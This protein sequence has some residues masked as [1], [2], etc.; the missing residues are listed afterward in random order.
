MKNN[1][2]FK[3]SFLVSFFFFLLFPGSAG[4]A[5]AADIST[6]SFNS[7]LNCYGAY[8]LPDTGQTVRYSVAAGDDS[9]YHPAAVQPKYT[10]Y[11]G[12]V[13]TSSYTVD[14]VTGRMWVTNPND[15][16]SG[17][18]VSS[19]TYTWGQAIARCEGLNYAGY[20][21]WRLPNIKE[22]MSIVDYNR[23][24]PSINTAY[25]LNTQS[26]YYWSS[27]TYMPGSTGAWNVFFSNGYMDGNGKTNSYYVRCV[28]GGP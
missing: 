14:N 23:Q 3:R 16:S 22:L 26:N 6:H 19:G 15:L 17:Q 24:G 9:D 11:Y 21:D 25:F 27:T 1:T 10:V 5:V 12:G 2:L 13:E 8:R 4:V 20:S 28:R 18:Y 7:G